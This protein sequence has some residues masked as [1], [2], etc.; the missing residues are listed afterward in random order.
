MKIRRTKRNGGKEVWELDIG[1]VDGRRRRL[2]FKTEKAAKLKSAEIK[3]D[4]EAAGRRWTNGG[5]SQKAKLIH[6]LEEI[7]ERGL[8]LDQVWDAYKSGKIA[9][10]HSGKKLSEAI[11]EVL[12]VKT[13]SNLRPKYLYELK[14]YLK[15]FA[16]GKESMDAGQLGVTEIEA[17]FTE[18]NESPSAR[19]GNLGKLSALFDHC[20]RR[21]YIKENPC[22]RVEKPHV[23]IGVPKVFSVEQCD[24]LMNTA[25]KTDKKII[26]ELALGL[27][28][29]VRPTEIARL[30]WDKIDLK[31]KLLTVDAAASKVRHRRLVSLQPACV[32]WLKLGGQLPSTI[33]HRRRMDDLKKAA[34]LED[35]PQDVLRH[36]AASHLVAL[37]GARTAAEM[38]GHSETMLFKHYRELVQPKET[39]RFWKILPLK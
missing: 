16:R 15:L 3:S 36:T 11:D 13:A 23:E 8:T 17:W 35:W 10:H 31:R 27:F 39:K 20:W 9:Q 4:F 38:L 32:A 14:R 21:G 24:R 22:L 6:I 37:C 30:N 19:I 5:T 28:A 29:G 34:Q 2:F 18:R 12:S 33:N 1:L 26:P 7:S 25:W